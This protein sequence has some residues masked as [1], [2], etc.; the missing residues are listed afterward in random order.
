MGRNNSSL[1]KS[2]LLRELLLAS[3][4]SMQDDEVGT[5]EGARGSRETSLDGEDVVLS[6]PG[7][8]GKPSRRG[9]FL[10][11]HTFLNPNMLSTGAGELD[12]W[13]GDTAI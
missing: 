5:A 13:V 6:K 4:R 9:T 1:R 8:R 10:I 11:V 2:R 3:D 12:S 7:K